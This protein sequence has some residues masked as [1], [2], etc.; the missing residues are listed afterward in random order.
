MRS[1]T[2]S[3]VALALLVSLFSAVGLTE[4][5]TVAEPDEI[6]AAEGRRTRSQPVSRDTTCSAL[7]AAAAQ[8]DLPTDWLLGPTLRRSAYGIGRTRVTRPPCGPRSKIKD[9]N[10]AHSTA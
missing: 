3:E 1:L 9:H 4:R 6:A 7:A 8:N 5:A 2:G 10:C